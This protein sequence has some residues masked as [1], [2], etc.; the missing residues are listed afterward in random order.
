[1]RVSGSAWVSSMAGFW[2]R[3]RW[4]IPVSFFFFPAFSSFIWNSFN[5]LELFGC[6]ERL[7]FFRLLK[8]YIVLAVSYRGRNGHRE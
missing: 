2:R 5:F 6:D 7:D 1:M 3:G 4:V 8:T